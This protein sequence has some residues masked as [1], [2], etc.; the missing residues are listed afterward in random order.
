MLYP[1][2]KDGEQKNLFAVFMRTQS[3]GRTGTGFPTGV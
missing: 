1:K 3:R 2:K